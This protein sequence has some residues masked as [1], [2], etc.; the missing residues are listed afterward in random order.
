M[1]VSGS[2][3]LEDGGWPKGRE[4]C[5]D[6]VFGCS[7]VCVWVV[8]VCLSTLACWLGDGWGPSTRLTVATVRKYIC[9]NSCRQV[10]VLLDLHI[11]S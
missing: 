2:V 10:E 9:R 6:L 4:C 11:N 3:G 7:E 1:W 8:C 5:F